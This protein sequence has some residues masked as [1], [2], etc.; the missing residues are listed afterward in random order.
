MI[1]KSTELSSHLFCIEKERHD[2]CNGLS[3]AIPVGM[4]SSKQFLSCL[5]SSTCAK[6]S[7]KNERPSVVPH[8][9]IM[10]E[11]VWLM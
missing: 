3:F 1:Y 8:E 6:D 5:E 7:D 11:T 2:F 10:Q 9:S 4:T